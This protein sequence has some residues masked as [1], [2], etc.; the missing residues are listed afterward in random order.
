[1]IALEPDLAEQVERVIRAPGTPGQPASKEP[2]PK[3]VVK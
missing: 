2:R 3:P 1:M